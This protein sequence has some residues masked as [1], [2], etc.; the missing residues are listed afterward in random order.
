VTSAAQVPS[1]LRVRLAALDPLAVD[2]VDDSAA[3][4]GHAGAA[5]GAGHFSVRIVS[6]RFS[7]L[8][9]LAR[10]RR[11]LDELTDLFPHPIHAL[12][13][14]AL[15]PEEFPSQPRRTMTP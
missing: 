7:G 12:S 6:D 3:H 5:G 9:R 4:A 10:H 14:E 8:S 11:V 15:T 1:E 13:I 2:V